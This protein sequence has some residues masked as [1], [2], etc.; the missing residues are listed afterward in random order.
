MTHVRICSLQDEMSVAFVLQLII[1]GLLTGGVYSLIALGL[2]L[3]FGV[4]KVINF[5]HGEM[6]VWGMY[7]AYTILVLTGIDPFFS[8]VVS[9]GVLF[10]FGYF[11][12]RVV[13][14]RIIQFPEAMQV[15]PMIGAALISYSEQTKPKPQ[16][17]AAA[18]KAG[19]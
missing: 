1:S 15:I 19:P 4:M 12:Q 5:A 18:E 7:I 11:I 3:I 9:A 17:P 8:L 13:V 6:M 16:P 2:S 10:V 14:N